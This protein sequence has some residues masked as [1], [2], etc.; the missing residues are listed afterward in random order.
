MLLR[1][2]FKH[3]SNLFLSG[4]VLQDLLRVR[5]LYKTTSSFADAIVR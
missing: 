3:M 1:L 5:S 2:T 4:E